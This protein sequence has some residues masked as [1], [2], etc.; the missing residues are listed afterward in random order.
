MNSKQSLIRRCVARLVRI[1]DYASPQD[2][3]LKL[4]K[5]EDLE[6]VMRYWHK[7]Q[8]I[9]LARAEEAL[10][11]GN[12][13]RCELWTARYKET[14]YRHEVEFRRP[15]IELTGKPDFFDANVERTHGAR[16]D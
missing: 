5:M 14:I 1:L 11:C 8:T 13:E 4:S 15:M 3:Q 16:K 6:K 9:A 2:V 12:D 10:V 7:E